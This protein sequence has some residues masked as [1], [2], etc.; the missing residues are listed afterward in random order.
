MSF[1]EVA[2]IGSP[3]APLTYSGPAGLVAGC[4][5]TISLRG[6]QT[7]GAVT[8]AVG[9]PP[10]S[11]RSL[12]VDTAG[13]HYSPQTLETAVFIAG[14]YQSSIGEALAL[15]VPAVPGMRY[16]YPDMAVDVRLSERQREAFDHAMHHPISLLFGD[17]GSGKTEIYITLIAA[18]LNAGQ[19]AVL[20]MPEI[21]LTP[22]MEKRLER[23]FGAGVAIWHSKQTK[24]TKDTILEGIATGRVRIVAGARSALFLPLASL[25][26]VIVDEE[27]DDSYKSSSRPRIHARD[28]AVAMGHKHG[29]RVV[30]GSATPSVA[31][32]H[33]YPVF[34]L[35]GTYFSGSRH[36]RFSPVSQTIGEETLQSVDAAVR[37]G[38]QV[39]VF[40][41]T[42]ANFK[43]LV[44]P[45]CHTTL[46]CPYCSVSMSLHKAKKAVECHYCHY[47]EP[48]PETCP[49]CGLAHL[50]EN[51]VGTDEIAALLG[52]R[53]PQMRIQKFDR[54]EVTTDSRLKKI[55]ADFNEGK[56]DILVGTQML[57]KGHDYHA[58]SLAVVIG[59]DY[60]LAMPDYKA[61]EK[62]MQLFVQISGRTGRKGEGTV[63]VETAYADLFSRF[64]D[65]YEPFIREE[66]ACRAPLYPPFSRLARIVVS[67]RDKERTHRATEQIASSLLG[68]EGVEV[69]GFGEAPISRISGKYRDA[70]LLRSTSAVR[71][72]DALRSVDHPWAQIDIDPVSFS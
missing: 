63:L 13:R 38:G 30:L 24:K 5:V 32:Y 19:T 56:I 54:D 7:L 61:R 22:Q 21:G 52:E 68:C 33:R 65:D 35:R 46:Q 37:G 58:I 47:I 6:R 40:V 66:L 39:I 4:V 36:Y 23:H 17:T 70:I 27:H 55:L 16:A 31:S 15:F 69:V 62:A 72:I 34:R 29:I 14:Y 71:L 44:C 28:V 64:I 3:L 42:R 43:A 11:C 9:E 51:R 53:Y 1:Y 8:A 18:A 12:E 57:A 50:D 26:L 10:F 41:P 20:L 2:V 25:G 45:L 67:H 48:I 60:L 49:A 59:L